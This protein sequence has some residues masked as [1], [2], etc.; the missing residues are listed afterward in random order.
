[1]GPSMMPTERS[2]VL[3]PAALDQILQDAF[4]D[5]DGSSWMIAAR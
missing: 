1:M 3:L 5:Y 2:F 4:M